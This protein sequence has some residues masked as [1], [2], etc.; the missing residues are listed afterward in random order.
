MSSERFAG[1]VTPPPAAAP[2]HPMAERPD[3]PERPKLRRI[4]GLRLTAVPSF[5]N[6]VQ[7]AGGAAAMYGVYLTWG[8]SIALVVGGVAVVVLGA[9]REGGRL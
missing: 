5:I 2:P 4:R 7:I 6:L 1:V 9:L 8:R 3:V